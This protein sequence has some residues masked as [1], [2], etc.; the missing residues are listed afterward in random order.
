MRPGSHSGNRSPRTGGCAHGCPPR[1]P[2]AG[3]DGRSARGLSPATGGACLPFPV[4]TG[5]SPPPCQAEPRLKSR[6]TIR[7]KHAPSSLVALHDMVTFSCQSPA[8]S[9]LMTMSHIPLS[10]RTAPGALFPPRLF[11]PDLFRRPWNWPDWP[12]SKAGP[13]PAGHPPHRH[14]VSGSLLGQ[15]GRAGRVPR[16]VCSRARQRAGW[17]LTLPPGTLLSPLC[18]VLTR[19]VGISTLCPPS[20]P[21]GTRGT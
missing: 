17:G 10:S 5:L 21:W 7:S 2:R 4:L 9:R 11:P 15:R 3:V 18:C 6:N 16:G 8:C 13:R 20:W 19:G 1:P 14:P 12:P